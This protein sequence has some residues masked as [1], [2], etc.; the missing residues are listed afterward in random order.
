MAVVVIVVIVLAATGVFNSKEMP[1]NSSNIT[2]VSQ[3]M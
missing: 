2:N 1:I 3:L